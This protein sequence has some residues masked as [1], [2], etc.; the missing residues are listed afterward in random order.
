MEQIKLKRC[1]MKDCPTC[2]NERIVAAADRAVA[3]VEQERFERQA[4]GRLH[5]R[6]VKGIST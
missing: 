6:K 5:S 4:A 2:Q 1:T 3:A